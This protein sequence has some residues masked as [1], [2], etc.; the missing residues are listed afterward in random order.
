MKANFKI[1]TIPISTPDDLVNELNQ[2][3]QTHQIIKISKDLVKENEQTCWCF[4][5][6]YLSG[7]EAKNQ[8]KPKSKIDYR[9]VLSPEDFTL[10][11]QIRD[12]RKKTAEK[13]GV[14]LYSVL[15]NEQMARIAEDKINSIEQLKNVD[16]IGEQRIK[17]YAG[18]IINILKKFVDE[19]NNR[20][21]NKKQVS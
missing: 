17:K 14:A 2:F 15:T 4:L 7:S 8:S 9:E 11:A 1:V 6:E 13:E 5:I 21:K 10:Y 19:K 20:E 12:W 16:G 18:D 3:V